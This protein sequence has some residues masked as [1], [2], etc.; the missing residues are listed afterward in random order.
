MVVFGIPL[1]LLPVL[2][3][4]LMRIVSWRRTTLTFVECIGTSYSCILCCVRQQCIGLYRLSETVAAY[5]ITMMRKKMRC[6]VCIF[7]R[8][9]I[10]R[11]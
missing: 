11:Y 8:M 6:E 7:T 2:G 3:K 4:P 9:E 10:H 5:S 1:G